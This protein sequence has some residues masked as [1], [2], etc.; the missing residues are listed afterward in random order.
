HIRRQI[1]RITSRGRLTWPRRDTSPRRP[2]AKILQQRRTIA[3]LPQLRKPLEDIDTALPHALFGYPPKQTLPIMLP[4]AI[5]DPPLLLTHFTPE[6]HLRP[7]RQILS[8]LLLGATQNKG[9]DQ[10][11]QPCRR[12]RIAIPVYRR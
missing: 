1:A 6:D 5:I 3:D 9:I 10:L 2:L 8:H 12:H 7:I 11:P 4:V